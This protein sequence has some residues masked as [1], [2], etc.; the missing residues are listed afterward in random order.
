MAMQ[1][2]II[3]L[4][5]VFQMFAVC[6]CIFSFTFIFQYFQSIFLRLV[7]INFQ[8]FLK[9]YKFHIIVHLNPTFLN[10]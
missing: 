1:S 5:S 6:L 7:L 10:R 4:F 3:P 8:L 2:V 9:C